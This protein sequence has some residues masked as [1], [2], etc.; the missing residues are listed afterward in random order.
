MIGCNPHFSLIGSGVHRERRTKGMLGL[1]QPEENRDEEEPI[2]RRP[3]RG[4]FSGCRRHLP[5]GGGESL[6][7]AFAGTVSVKNRLARRI[8]AG[9]FNQGC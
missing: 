8:R 9:A 4:G 1:S 3:D 7:M 5:G 2:Y 6:N